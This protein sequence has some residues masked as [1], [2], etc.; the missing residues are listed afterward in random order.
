LTLN[1]IEVS[2]NRG[3]IANGGFNIR[4]VLRFEVVPEFYRRIGDVRWLRRNNT[5]TTTAGDREYDLPRDFRSM[6]AVY[7]SSAATGEKPGE[8]RY[9]GED[10]A[11][12]AQAE[13]NTQPGPPSGF[14]IV[15]HST[16]ETFR[17]LKLDAPPDQAYTMPY[18]YR[19]RL[20]FAN[21]NDNIDLDRYIPED[22]QQGLIY[23]LRAEIYLDRFSQNDPRYGVAL[24][25]FAE[26]I[27]QAKEGASDLARRN[28]A[29]Y[30]D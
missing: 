12:V 6:I 16:E 17:A 26:V 1:D 10:P 9:I 27:E 14:W 11:L 13:L 3:N 19:S 30:A 7:R 20:V 4:R 2:A 25:K 28:H 8:L 21:E 29:I 24:N 22:Y 18:V 5:I 23:G 15:K